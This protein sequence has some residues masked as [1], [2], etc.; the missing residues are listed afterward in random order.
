MCIKIRRLGP[1]Q[2]GAFKAK[3]N[4]PQKQG[5][6]QTKPSKRVALVLGITKTLGKGRSNQNP[7]L[8]GF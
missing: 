8:P 2:L 4:K 1:I 7:G 5:D 3:Q 6:T